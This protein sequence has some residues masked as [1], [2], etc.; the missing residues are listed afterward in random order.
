VVCGL[1]FAVSGLV[2]L[3]GFTD[4]VVPRTLLMSSKALHAELRVWGLGF[5][6]WGLGFEVYNVQ[7]KIRGFM[8]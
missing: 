4:L 7:F 8:Y 1:W 6:V 2:L 3:Y 5:G